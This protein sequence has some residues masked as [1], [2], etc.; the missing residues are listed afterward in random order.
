MMA[1]RAKRL[2]LKKSREYT[3]E[4]AAEI[5]AAFFDVFKK[6]YKGCEC[7]LH[8]AICLIYTKLKN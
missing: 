2:A 8:D 4:E 3:K 5:K 6:E 7:Q 1:E